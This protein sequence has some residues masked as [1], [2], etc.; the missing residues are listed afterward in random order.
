MRSQ[1]IR[2][3]LV[4]AKTPVVNACKRWLSTI[5]PYQPMDGRKEIIE[6][7]YASGILDYLKGV[8]ELSRFSVVVGYCHYFKNKRAILEIGCSEGILQE[9]LDYSKYFRYVGVDISTETIRGASQKQD[10][11]TTF[12]AEDASMY[13]PNELFYV[14]IFNECLEYFADP[15]G[16]VL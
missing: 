6:A 16:L 9:R 15:L 4:E 11:K 2:R 14:I 10:D 1:K 3:Y 5:L 8:D 13:C 7:E 12:I